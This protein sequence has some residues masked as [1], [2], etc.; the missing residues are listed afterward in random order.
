MTKIFTLLA[1]FFSCYTTAQT[2]CGTA[3]EG[4][5]VTLTAPPGY[6]FTS[7]TFASYGTPNG[8]CGSFTTGG[9]HA[10]NSLSIC[11]AQ[12]V[13]NNSAGIGASNGVFG[14]PCG[15]TVKRLYI[16]AVYSILLPLKLVSFSLQNFSQSNVRLSWSSA[17]EFNTSHF[18]IER[19]PDGISFEEAGTVTAAGSGDHH[20]SFISMIP[21]AATTCF[22]RLKM[23]DADGRHVYSSILRADTKGSGL[24]LSVYPN[25]AAALLTVVSNKIQEATITNSKGQIMKNLLLING[26]QTLTVSDWVS[27]IYFII[28]PEGVSKFIKR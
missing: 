22:F 26:S 21:G 13:G 4:G 10:A 8:S 2:I 18:V 24:N 27:G 23:M 14:D 19:S 28:T 5:T 17:N 12:L 7:V 1:L 15:G 25:P 11:S 9:C 3:N 20:Y 16:E 6:V